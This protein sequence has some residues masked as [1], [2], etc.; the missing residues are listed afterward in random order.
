MV[1]T[2]CINSDKG[3]RFGGTCAYFLPCIGAPKA[4]PAK[5][6]TE[7]EEGRQKRTRR[8]RGV[9]QAHAARPREE[10]EDEEINLIKDLKRHARLAV[11]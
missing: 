5:Q 7:K 10:E 8:R 9:D 1:L 11:A 2:F 4:C 3:I 6:K